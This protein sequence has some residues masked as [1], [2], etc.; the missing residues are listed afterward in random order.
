MCTFKV[1]DLVLLYDNKFEKIPGK[2]RMHSLG[3]YVVKEVTNRG[4][5]QLVKLNGEPF[6]GKVNDSHLKPYTGGPTI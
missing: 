1:N 6:P 2:F 3:P 5:V 4:E